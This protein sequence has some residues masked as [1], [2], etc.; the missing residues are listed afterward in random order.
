VSG[1]AALVAHGWIRTTGPAGR[2]PPADAG[3]S[4]HQRAGIG[5]RL[6]E[7][8]RRRRPGKR[9][10]AAFAA[11]QATATIA[12]AAARGFVERYR[13]IGWRIDPSSFDPDAHP[14]RPMPDGVRLATLAEVD[15]PELR[16]S[17]HALA[18]ET[19][20]DVPSPDPFPAPTYAEW[21]RDTMGGPRFEPRTYILAMVGARPVGECWIVIDGQTAWN[22]FTAVARSHRGRGIA[23]HLKV[24]SLALT[25]RLGIRELR[26]E[27]HTLNTG[28]LAINERLG[29]QR[30]PGFIRFGRDL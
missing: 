30:R 18:I 27:N 23:M 5:S 24:A 8:L 26:S 14:L 19:E 6:L 1:P 7:A 28:M 2:L 21:E 16:R 22:H 11:E 29:F 15:A 4:R 17:L 13:L 10:V 3:R 12:F 25:R 9:E 20:V